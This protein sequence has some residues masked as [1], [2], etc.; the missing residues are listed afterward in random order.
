MAKSHEVPEG[1]HLIFRPYR[2]LKDGTILWAKAYGIR[3]WPILVKD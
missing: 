2:R 1:Y 3:A